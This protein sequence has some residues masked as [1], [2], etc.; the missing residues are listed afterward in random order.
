MRRDF[1]ILVCSFHIIMLYASH[2]MSV[3]VL[4]LN[5]SFNSHTPLYT[6]LFNFPN[7]GLVSFSMPCKYQDNIHNVMDFLILLTSPLDK[8]SHCQEKSIFIKLTNPEFLFELNCR[9]RKAN[10]F[11]VCGLSGSLGTRVTC[12]SPQLMSSPDSLHL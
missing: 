3:A 9:L 12:F 1:S 6:L 10:C 11:I 2:L 4:A 8:F 7:C 5:R